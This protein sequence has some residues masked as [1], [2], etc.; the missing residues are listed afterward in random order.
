M[1]KCVKATV[2]KSAHELLEDMRVLEAKVLLKQST[3]SIG[4]IAFKIGKFEPSD[5]S[6]FFKSKTNITPKQYRSINP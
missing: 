4:E 5:F 2:G 3:M 6:R 1:H